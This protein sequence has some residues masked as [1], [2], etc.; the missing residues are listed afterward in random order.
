M[1]Q[2]QRVRGTKNYETSRSRKQWP[3][4]VSRIRKVK[5]KNNTAIRYEETAK[6]YPLLF[7][8]RAR[9]TK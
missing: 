4:H 6:K 9:V 2:T 8:N 7:K 3:L 5:R 1:R